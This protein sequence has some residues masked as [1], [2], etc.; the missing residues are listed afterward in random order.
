[1]QM[2]LSNKYRKRCCRDQYMKP[3]C[4]WLHIKNIFCLDGLNH[5]ITGW[6]KASGLCRSLFPLPLQAGAAHSPASPFCFRS[7]LRWVSISHWISHSSENSIWS[8][9]YLLIYYYFVSLWFFLQSHWIHFGFLTLNFQDLW[10]FQ[11]GRSPKTAVGHGD[12]SITS[13]TFTP[14]VTENW[15]ATLW[16][17][18]NSPELPNGN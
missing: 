2:S 6:R 1:M 8:L 12:S 5:I 3:V 18:T 16:T 4:L 10:S 7:V 11:F 14:V 15:V 17:Y 13:L 9:E